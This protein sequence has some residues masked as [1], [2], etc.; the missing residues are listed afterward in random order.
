[1]SFL[2]LED[3]FLTRLHVDFSFSKEAEVHVERLS[4]DF[5]YDVLTHQDDPLRRMLTLRVSLGEV[6]EDGSKVAHQ[7]E[8]EI[9]GQFRIPEDMEEN[10]REG[11][12]RVNGLSMLYSTLR[13]IIGN[14][15]G[16]FP[17]GRFC[18]PAILPQEVVERVEETKK[19]AKA[20]ATIPKKKAAKKR[21]TK[22]S[23]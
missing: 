11:M 6:T 12:I 4:L 17:A 14:L 9:N 15:S 13:G 7:V 22:K 1:M 21:I 2:Q 19:A 5:D 23:K 18:L 16:S 10:Q 20:K 3:Y 8:C